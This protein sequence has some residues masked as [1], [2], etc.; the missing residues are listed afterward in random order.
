MCA[1]TNSTLLTR[2]FF[3][4][5]IHQEVVTYENE[6]EEAICTYIESLLENNYNENGNV[7]GNESFDYRRWNQRSEYIKLVRKTSP[8]QRL[9]I[10]TGLVVVFALFGY[11]AYLHRTLTTRGRSGGQPPMWGRKH[12]NDDTTDWDHAMPGEWYLSDRWSEHRRDSGISAIRS[13]DDGSLSSP[14]Y[15]PYGAPVPVTTTRTTSN[16]NH[17][18]GAM[19]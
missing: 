9:V 6:N 8:L 17:S 11:A 15:V 2:P 12:D 19:A 5:L 1:C 10:V 3:S 13:K 7:V 18:D 4:W 16:D 14:A